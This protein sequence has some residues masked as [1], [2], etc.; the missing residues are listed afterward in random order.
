MSVPDTGNKI[1]EARE[2]A[3]VTQRVLAD[4]LGVT[5]QTVG[6]W[7]R[8]VTTPKFEIWQVCLLMQWLE[9]T[10]LEQLK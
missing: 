1:K 6:N 7:E 9:I 3:G 4:G 2:A 5:I 8:G 10:N